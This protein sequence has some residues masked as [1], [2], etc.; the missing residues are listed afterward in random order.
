LD[1]D[2]NDT[3]IDPTIL[4]DKILIEWE[5]KAIEWLYENLDEQEYYQQHLEDLK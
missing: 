2:E 3:V 4:S 1:H 5:Q